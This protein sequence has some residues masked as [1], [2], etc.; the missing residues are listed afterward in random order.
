MVKGSFLTED[1]YLGDIRNP[2][3][4]NRYSYCIGNPLFYDDP[5]GYDPRQI[6]IKYNDDVK[7]Y[8]K[9]K[10]FVESAY[11]NKSKEE[12]EKEYNKRVTFFNALE[13]MSEYQYC[14]EDVI[15][16]DFGYDTI[17]G[18]NYMDNLI[19]EA[20]YLQMMELCRR[21]EAGTPI[22]E[23]T[24]DGWLDLYNIPTVNQHGRLVKIPWGRPRGAGTSWKSYEA[25]YNKEYG[26]INEYAYGVVKDQWKFEDENNKLGMIRS[27][28]ENG[29]NRYW[30]AVGPRVMTP[31][32]STVKGKEIPLDVMKYGTKIDVIIR[33]SNFNVYYVP[34]IVGDAKEHTYGN[35]IYQ[36]GFSWKSQEDEASEDSDSAVIEFIRK[37]PVAEGDK[38]INTPEF[39]I[40]GII[41]YD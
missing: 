40:L 5:S 11:S 2:L 1:R 22:L 25:K 8:K 6:L 9:I 31:N 36:T 7:E 32:Y 41:V 35:G 28:D 34:A 12:R 20:H 26:Y 38:L 33:D 16:Y 30:V 24:F 19:G 29:I 10:D 13:Y 3:T 4:L 18:Q 37:P 14:A 39:D 21:D 27:V 23:K 15:D 17:Y